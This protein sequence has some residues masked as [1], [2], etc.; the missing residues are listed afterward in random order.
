MI[1]HCTREGGSISEYQTPCRPPFFH[2]FKYRVTVTSPVSSLSSFR[3][4]PEIHH[5][6]FL[7]S[8]FVPLEVFTCFP[9]SPASFSLLPGSML[10]LTPAS[11]RDNLLPKGLIQKALNGSTAHAWDQ[12]QCSGIPC[13]NHVFKFFAGIGNRLLSG[14]MHLTTLCAL[15]SS[16]VVVDF[17]EPSSNAPPFPSVYAVWESLLTSHRSKFS[18]RWDDLCSFIEVQMP[19]ILYRRS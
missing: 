17:F 8:S 14:S 2:P 16:H 3:V 6:F 7:L 1:F 11:V 15:M 10:A 18:G 12:W 4:S 19:S 5:C 9:L 13:L